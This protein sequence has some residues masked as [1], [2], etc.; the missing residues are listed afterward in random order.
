MIAKL[1]NEKLGKIL[2][3][4][5]KKQARGYNKNILNSTEHEIYPAHLFLTFISTTNTAS[6]R[7][8]ARHFFIC[9][10][11]NLYEPLKFRVQLEM[12]MKKVL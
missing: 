12:S 5:T 4:T 7:L 2:S 6:E 10:Y 9:R 3:T 11:F 8:K 1:E